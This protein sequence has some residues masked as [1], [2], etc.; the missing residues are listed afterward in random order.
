VRAQRDEP[1]LVAPDD[2]ERTKELIAELTDQRH[3]FARQFSERTR[4][5]L[6]SADPD[7][8]DEGRAFPTWTPAARDAILQPP[9]PQIEPSPRI[10]ERVRGHDLDLEAA[11]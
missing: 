5:T 11:D 10:L 2:I 9:K 8:G 3:E 6:H 7:H 4:L 1:A